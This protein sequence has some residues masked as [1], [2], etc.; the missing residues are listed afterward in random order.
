MSQK[1]ETTLTQV[2]A[3]RPYQKPAAPQEFGELR[4]IT[5]GD[6]SY[7][8]SDGAFNSAGGAP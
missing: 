3:K 7:I 6:F 8:A 5:L 2:K 1:P 4:T